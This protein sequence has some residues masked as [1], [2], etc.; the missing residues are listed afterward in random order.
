MASNLS[1]SDRVPVTRRSSLAAS[2]GAGVLAAVVGYLVTYLLVSGEVRDAFG[3]DVATWKGVAWYFYEAHLVD[4]QAS[5]Q[6]GS[7]GGTRTLD[8]IA[9]SD[10]AGAGLL[11]VLPPLVLVAAGGLLAVRW[12]ATDLGE[13]VIVGAPVAVGYGAVVGL[14]ALVAEASAS[15][16]AFGIEATTSTGPELLPAI[17]LG[18]VLYPLVFATAGAVLAVATR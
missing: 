2:A 1:A 7:L 18:G 16:S 8:L 13:A 11:Y 14:G 5:S 4:I 15:G 6:V 3:D 12:N 17:V 10:S 9:Q